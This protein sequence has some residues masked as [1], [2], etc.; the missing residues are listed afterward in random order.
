VSIDTRG[1]EFREFT[2]KMD[3]LIEAIQQSNQAAREVG[4]KMVAELGAGLEYIEG[5]KP[6]RK[7]ID[8]LL[9]R[10]LYAAAAIFAGTVVAELAKEAVKVLIK[11]IGPE[12]EIQL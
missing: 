3:R 4:E 10:P 11:L 2:G 7:V 6:S 9:L 5:P 12:I 1:A 8:L